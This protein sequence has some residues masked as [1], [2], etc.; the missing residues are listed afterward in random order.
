LPSMEDECSYAP[1]A[2]HLRYASHLGYRSSEE[3]L[4]RDIVGSLD[5]LAHVEYA[6]AIGFSGVQYALARGRPIAEQHAVG[7]ALARLGLEAGCVI[8]TTFDKIRRPLWS[9]AGDEARATL[10]EEL[11]VGF[12]TARRVGSRYLAVLAGLDPNKEDDPQR[13]AFVE[14]LRWA[15]QRAETAEVVLLLESVDRNRLPGMLL[16]HIADAHEI[17]AAIDSPSLRLIF[18]TAHVQAM[19]GDL[20]AHLE[21]T[22]DSIAVVQFADTPGR[23]E[24]GTGEVD[25]A[26]VLGALK[27]RGFRGLV[28]LEFGWSTPGREAELSGLERLRQLDAAE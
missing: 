20:I 14:N 25:F 5:P 11:A 15:A 8:Y 21:A 23:L 28:E 9:D 26:S 18:D 1:M 4:F 13:A 27:R 22:W 19:D 2:W 6:A 24:P 10:A 7:A 12:E 16:H 17:V 3:P